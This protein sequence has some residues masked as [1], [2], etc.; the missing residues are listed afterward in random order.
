MSLDPPQ[1]A[2]EKPVAWTAMPYRA[3]VLGAAGDEIGP[4]ESLVGDEAADIFHGIV[5]GRKGRMLE[6]P[7]T[8]ITRI[9][10]EKVYT[11]LAS[12]EVDGLNDYQATPTYKAEWGGLFRKHP[13]WNKAEGDY[14]PLP[15]PGSGTDRG[16][17]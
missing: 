12:D 10:T 13:K 8:R 5:V 2:D 14:P 4:A 3:P 6:L 17:L 16:S 1:D 15:S 11:D 9:T 7:A